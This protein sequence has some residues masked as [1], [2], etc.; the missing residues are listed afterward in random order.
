MLVNE[1]QINYGGSASDQFGLLSS[2]LRLFV[3]QFHV[4]IEREDESVVGWRGS[5]WGEGQLSP[6][7]KTFFGWDF[8]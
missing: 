2:C 7:S 6:A 4:L 1:S 8:Q 3:A 5:G